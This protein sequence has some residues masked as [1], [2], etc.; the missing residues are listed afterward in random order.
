MRP[1]PLGT[2]TGLRGADLGLIWTDPVYIVTETRFGG[3][4]H[5]HMIRKR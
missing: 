3:A 1:G 4:E 2:D 5:V